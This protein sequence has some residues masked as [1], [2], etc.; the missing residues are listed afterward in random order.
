MSSVWSIYSFSSLSYDRSEAS[1][2]LHI[3]RSRASSFKWEYPF[4]SLRSS[5]NFRR[6]LPRIPVTS[7][8][9]FIFPSIT[10]CRRQFLRKMSPIH[11]AFR[12][13]ISCR[14]FLCSLTPSNTSWS[15]FEQ[16]FE[17]RTANQYYIRYCSTS[18]EVIFDTQVSIIGRYVDRVQGL[19]NQG[20]LAFTSEVRSFI[21]WNPK[22]E[23]SEICSTL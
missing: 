23:I 13:L 5:S 10:R 8:P 6:L 14:I 11:L 21:I 17:F 15:I 2:G 12:L 4:L 16:N 20:R 9:L 7:I 22:S 3:V 19:T 18:I 1:W